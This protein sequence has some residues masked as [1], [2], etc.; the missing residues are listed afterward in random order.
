V[1]LIL[2]AVKRRPDGDSELLT[3]SVCREKNLGWRHFSTHLFSRE[4]KLG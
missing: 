3:R 1:P 2:L 4:T